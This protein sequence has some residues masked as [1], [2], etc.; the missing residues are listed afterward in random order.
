MI[1]TL[2]ALLRLVKAFKLVLRNNRQV[3]GLCHVL[4]CICRTKKRRVNRVILEA[5]KAALHVE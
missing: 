4:V 2:N 1:K 5:D 3:Q